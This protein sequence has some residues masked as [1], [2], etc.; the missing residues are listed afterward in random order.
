[1]SSTHRLD[2]GEFGCCC[3]FLC[4]HWTAGDTEDAWLRLGL[5]H[6][7]GDG[8]HEDVP[9]SLWDGGNDDGEERDLVG[10]L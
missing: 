3:S 9:V 5:S 10:C 8:G 7:L 2:V 1:M 6:H 4:Y